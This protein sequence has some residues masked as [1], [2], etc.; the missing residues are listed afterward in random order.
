MVLRYF[1]QEKREK[2]ELH[3]AMAEEMGIT[4]NTLRLRVLRLKQKL[5]PCV[6]RCLERADVF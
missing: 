5:Q 6:E 3:N 1:S 4:I 2:V